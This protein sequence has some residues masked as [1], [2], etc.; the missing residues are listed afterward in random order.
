M[1]LTA[2][3]LSDEE[4]VFT[5]VRTPKTVDAW[6][7][8]WADAARSEA[9][10]PWRLGELFSQGRQFVK[11]TENPKATYR[12]VYKNLPALG[13]LV[14]EFRYLRELAEVSDAF[15]SDQRNP[16][17][18]WGHHREV[19][20][21]GVSVSEQKRKWLEK[22]EKENWSKADLRMAIAGRT[23]AKAVENPVSFVA[24]RWSDQGVAGLRELFPVGK[25]IN[26]ELAGAVALELAELFEAFRRVGL[27]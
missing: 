15:P 22:A 3:A 8:M 26:K 25:P 12:E 2:S 20:A 13:P 23:R 4:I 17:V 21:A 16:R 7:S 5:E 10:R 27:L 6:R 19:W 9:D 14:L 18:S 11:A 1:I 24:R